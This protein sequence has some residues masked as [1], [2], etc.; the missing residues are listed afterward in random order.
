MK[1]ARSPVRLSRRRSTRASLAARLGPWTI[2]WLVL[3]SVAFGAG[4]QVADAVKARNRSALTTLLKQSAD[5]NLPQPDGTTA[6][7]SR[8][9]KEYAKGIR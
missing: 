9:S 6:L 8:Q 4:P 2:A 7:H 5:V 3:S 1:T